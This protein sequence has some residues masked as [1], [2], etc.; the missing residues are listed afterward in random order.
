MPS[1][2]TRAGKTLCAAYARDPYLERTEK[3]RYSRLEEADDHHLEEVGA[4]D[5]RGSSAP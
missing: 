2:T 4:R 1:I 3:E 5:S